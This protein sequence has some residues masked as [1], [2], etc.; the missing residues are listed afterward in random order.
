MPISS[1]EFF[2]K[3]NAGNLYGFEVVIREYED[4]AE[5]RSLILEG[6][7]HSIQHNI[8]FRDFS[9]MSLQQFIIREA[10]DQFKPEV[11]VAV[12]KKYHVTGVWYRISKDV[13]PEYVSSTLAKIVSALNEEEDNPTLPAESANATAGAGETIDDPLTAF[14]D[15]LGD[16]TKA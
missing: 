4:N 10:I 5:L 9:G 8:N 1:T 13:Y 6:I 3:V 14:T 16:D 2:T 11:A 7:D 12:A 15:L